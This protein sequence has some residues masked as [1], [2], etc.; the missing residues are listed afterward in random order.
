MLQCTDPVLTIAA[1]LGY[2]RPVFLSPA[3]A[4]AE[5]DAARTAIIEGAAGGRTLAAKSDHVA[6]VY[7][8]NEFRRRRREEGFS[9]ARRWCG[10]MFVSFE[11]MDAIQSGRADYAN[12]LAELGFVSDGALPS[13]VACRAL[14][15]NAGCCNP[16]LL[17]GCRASAVVHV[18]CHVTDCGVHASAES[19]YNHVCQSTLASS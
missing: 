12:C 17:H 13:D 2:G 18:Q 4:R 7:A 11:A 15:S 16:D 9:A 3:Q 19:L 10:D 14:A 1:A 8:F 6:V 5:A